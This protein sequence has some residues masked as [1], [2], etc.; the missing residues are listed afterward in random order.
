VWSP[1]DRKV[2]VAAEICDIFELIRASVEGVDS[3]DEAWIKWRK[4]GFAMR[5]SEISGLNLT[6][7]KAKLHLDGV[8][9][10]RLESFAAELKRE[11]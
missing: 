1:D 6:R 7:E 4:G 10:R 5:F 8:I 2:P 9:K 3:T 11:H